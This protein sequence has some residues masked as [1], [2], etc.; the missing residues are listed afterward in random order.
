M[1]TRWQEWLIAVCVAALSLLGVWMVF[2]D[3]LVQL[4]QPPSGP[5]STSQMPSEA[6]LGK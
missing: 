1:D 2:G 5:A 4:F 3:D 6:R